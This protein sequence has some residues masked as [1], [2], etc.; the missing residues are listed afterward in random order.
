MNDLTLS[1]FLH[2]DHVENSQATLIIIKALT[3][4]HRK[5]WGL[6]WW[7]SCGCCWWWCWC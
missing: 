2:Y 5:R 1:Q 4:F 3:K 6:C 7:W